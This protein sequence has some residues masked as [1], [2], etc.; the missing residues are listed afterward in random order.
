[1]GDDDE[2]DD[3]GGKL[4]DKLCGGFASCDK[5]G[6]D[7][8]HKGAQ[9]CI[10]SDDDAAKYSISASSC[11]SRISTGGCTQATLKAASASCASKYSGVADLSQAVCS[12][13]GGL[14]TGLKGC[15]PTANKCRISPAD[16]SKFSLDPSCHTPNTCTLA[17]LQATSAPACKFTAMGP[18]PNTF[19]A[20]CAAD[21]GYFT[22]ITGC[23]VR[24]KRCRL[25]VLDGLK[26]IVDPTCYRPGF[27]TEAT[28]KSSN[29][30]RC[31]LPLF[32]PPAAVSAAACLVDN[33]EFTGITGCDGVLAPNKCSMSA[34]DAAKFAAVDS[35]CYAPS[36]C[37]EATLKASASAVC[38]AAGY[39]PSPSLSSGVCGSSGGV[40]TGLSGCTVAPPKKCS[41]SAG[42]AAKFAAVD[43]TCYAPS[44]LR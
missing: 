36:T 33:G 5:D 32:G 30:P 3:N 23:D 44:T 6:S 22:G 43:S 10:L 35:T 27:C 24:M 25:S 31:S 1:M 9:K 18:A 13:N 26:Y 8:D 20:A 21:G 39:T 4:S 41:L 17:K 29:A 34:S 14:F 40:F 28:L 7:S 42:D 11:Y 19:S 2:D 38:A 37:T 12:G 15:I 16:S